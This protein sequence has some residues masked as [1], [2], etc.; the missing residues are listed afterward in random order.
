MHTIR[1]PGHRRGVLTWL[2]VCGLV[3]LAGAQERDHK[4][5]LDTIFLHAED[6]FRDIMGSGQDSGIF[7]RP[8]LIPGRGEMKIGRFPNA[9]TLNWVIPLAQSA[10]VQADA[11]AFMRVKFADRKNYT[12]VSDGSEEEG[13]RITNVYVNATGKPKLIFQT[14]YYRNRDEPAKSSFAITVY[15]TKPVSGSSAPGTG[16]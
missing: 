7:V 2:L 1:R 16:F 4:T 10:Q 11:R 15:G 12:I 3:F 5:M 9:V 13:Y 6:N 14:T 8:K